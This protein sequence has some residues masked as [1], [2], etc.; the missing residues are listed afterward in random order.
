M[1]LTARQNGSVTIVSTVGSI[2]TLTAEDVF[3]F[4][5]QQVQQGNVRLV[6]DLSRVDYISSAGL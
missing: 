6:A 4:L 5:N 1:E 2:D 3:T